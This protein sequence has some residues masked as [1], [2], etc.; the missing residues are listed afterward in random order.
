MTIYYLVFSDLLKNNNIIDTAAQCMSDSRYKSYLELTDEHARAQNVVAY[1]L[2]LKLLRDFNIPITS[3][4]LDYNEFEKPYFKDINI[5]F[6][7]S[8]TD[9]VVA[10][11]I[12]DTE[13]GIDIEKIEDTNHSLI[14]WVYSKEEQNR[15]QERLL[16]KDF[17]FR[18]WTIKESYIKYE[19]SGLNLDFKAINFDLEKEIIEVN[20]TFIQSVLIND[21][22]LSICGEEK[23]YQL[24]EISPKQL[25][26]LS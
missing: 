21:F 3:L 11:A 10:V 15:F 18:A 13:I 4:E 2:L 8:H 26:D 25:F 19:G 7:I 5:K 20:G 9:D 12:S 1:Y 24:K 22:Y 6:N 23:E 14:D 17:F 16:D